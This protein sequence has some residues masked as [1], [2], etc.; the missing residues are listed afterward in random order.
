MGRAKK[1]FKKVGDFVTN[2]FVVTQRGNDYD[3]SIDGKNLFKNKLF[4]EGG[5]DTLKAFGARNELYGGSGDDFLRA[6]GVS[7]KMRGEAG[8]DEIVGLGLHN[9]M[10]GGTGNDTLRGAG[11]YNDMRGDEGNDELIGIGAYNA[12]NGGADDDVVVG[13]GAYNDMKGGAGADRL[14][15]I[16]AINRM[17]GGSGNDVV[18]AAGAVNHIHGGAGNDL[19]T[20]IGGANIIYGDDGDDIIVAGGLSNTVYGGAGDDI[21]VSVGGVNGMDGGEGND[22]MVAAGLLAT[23]QDGGAGDDV[24]IA[25]STAANVQH[26]GAG[27]DKMVALSQGGNYQ[28][29][30]SGNDILVGIGAGN[31][32]FG[33]DGDD[34]MVGLGNLNEQR[35]GSGNDIMVGIGK[36]N[37]Q[38]GDDGNDILVGLGVLGNI[39]HGGAG[40]D[41]LFSLGQANLQKGQAGDDIM[42]ALGRVNVQIGGAGDDIAFALGQASLQ[43]GE[44]GDD[45]L[46][47]AGQANIQHGGA[48]DDIML[49]IGKGN[50]QMGSGGSDIVIGLGKGNVQF[51]GDVLDVVPEGAGGDEPDAAPEGSDGDALDAVPDELGLDSQN[52]D[53]FARHT[54]AGQEGTDTNILVAAGKGN[55]Q[56]GDAGRDIA[57]TLGEANLQLLGKGD[58]VGVALGKKAS[59]QFG[60]AGKDVLVNMQFAK[61]GGVYQS[62]GGDSDTMITFFGGANKSPLG[63]QM[64]DSGDDVM[65]MISQDF[66]KELFDKKK[67]SGSDSKATGQG[68]GVT[69]QSGGSGD[70]TFIDLATGTTLRSGGA[71]NDTFFSLGKGGIAFGGD[72]NDLMIGGFKQSSFYA[73]G[74]GDDVMLDMNSF[75]GIMLTKHLV[76]PALEMV[77]KMVDKVVAN[78]L[79]EIQFVIDGIDGVFTGIGDFLAAIELHFP[80]IALPDIPF[81][82]NFD[83][84]LDKFAK[85]LDALNLDIPLDEVVA[86]L[87]AK[88]SE[89]LTNAVDLL[90]TDI[91]NQVLGAVAETVNGLVGQVT[92]AAMDLAKV[93]EL[94]F[95]GVIGT[96]LDGVELVVDGVEGTIRGIED[97]AEYLANGIDGALEDILDALTISLPDLSLDLG[98]EFDF[99]PDFNFLDHIGDFAGAILDTIKNFDFSAGLDFVA[100][101]TEA[102]G[103][104]IKSIADAASLDGIRE[105]LEALGDGI[106]D[107]VDG[108]AAFFEDMPDFGAILDAIGGAIPDLGDVPDVIGKFMPEGLEDLGTKLL[109]LY[110]LSG[111][112][113]LLGGDGDDTFGISGKDTKAFGGAGDD[114]YLVSLNKIDVAFIS[115]GKLDGDLMDAISAAGDAITAVDGGDAGL[116]SEAGGADTLEL[117]ALLGVAPSEVSITRVPDDIPL[118]GGSLIVTYVTAARAAANA[119]AIYNMKDLFSFDEGVTSFEDKAR[120]VAAKLT[121]TAKGIADNMKTVFLTNMENEDKRIETLRLVSLD[122]E[123][124]EIDLAGA[125]EA[126]VFSTLPTEANSSD[127]A[128]FVT[129]NN[130]AAE[131]RLALEE[132][133]EEGTETIRDGVKDLFNDIKDAGQD[134]LD[135]GSAL[136]TVEVEEAPD[137]ETYKEEFDENAT[138]KDFLTDEEMA[139]KDERGDKN[140]G[141]Y[142]EEAGVDLP[143]PPQALTMIVNELNVYS[144]E[145][146]QTLA[147]TD[148][149]FLVLWAADETSGPHKIHAQRVDASGQKIGAETLLATDAVSVHQWE[150][151]ALADNEFVLRA[152]NYK[153][154]EHR[155]RALS[156]G[157]IVKLADPA[158]GT[159]FKYYLKTITLT[160]GNEVRID[161]IRYQ[162]HEAKAAVSMYDPDG[163]HTLVNGHF[164][165]SDYMRQ[166]DLVALADGGFVVVFQHTKNDRDLF[167]RIYNEDG[168]ARTGYLNPALNAAAHSED[169]E[170]QLAALADGSFLLAYFKD[171]GDDEIHVIRLDATGEKIGEDLVISGSYAHPSIAAQADGT[172]AITYVSNGQVFTAFKAYGLDLEGTAAADLIEGG[173]GDD[174]IEAGLGDDAIFGDEGDDILHGE[175]GDDFIE[176]G[177]G[178]DRLDGGAGRDVL[179][180]GAGDDVLTG[181]SGA[182]TFVFSIAGTGIFGTDTITDFAPGED[183]LDLL[184]LAGIDSFDDLIFSQDGADTVISTQGGTI[185]LEDTLVEDITEDDVAHRGN[186]VGEYGTIQVNEEVQ[187]ISTLQHYENPVVVA[188][189]KSLNEIDIVEARVSNVSSNG[190]DIQLQETEDLDGTHAIETVQFMVVEAGR[191]ELSNGAVIEAGTVSTN[192][193]FQSTR[194]AMPEE[195]T[196]EGELS[197]AD[198]RV[199]A[200]VNSRNGPEFATARVDDVSETGFKISMAEREADRSGHLSETIGF[201]AFQDGD[202]GAFETGL[203]NL[204]DVRQSVPETLDFAQITEINGID[205]AILR[206][207][208]ETGEVFVQEDLSYD[209]ETEH[210]QDEVS[211]LIFEQD[212]GLLLV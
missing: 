128:A 158:D 72:G 134:L 59:V 184:G 139:A 62:G 126:G 39:Q 74:A 88:L 78:I 86:E 18:V 67:S 97:I 209:A 101:V 1:F 176:G 194:R 117:R 132:K 17:D 34:V 24:M 103:Q 145:V 185:R 16:G 108:I 160:N 198:T 205:P 196:F 52:K 11:A 124:T 147:M 107:G 171:H 146:T 127:L 190:F 23:T 66:Y 96:L 35:G 163:N 203:L 95:D 36:G 192:A 114:T 49:A 211:F 148:G 87:H 79:T 165:A 151:M 80:G 129:Q 164:A 172:V 69:F 55:L 51:G 98:F 9:D 48:D 70:D 33:E 136:E 175:D 166:G 188:F 156:D 182:D 91:V 21:M 99:L 174:S 64:G 12:M 4:G 144:L 7:N 40:N 73:G 75:V 46:V 8:N 204:T 94:A 167:V 90:D 5:D 2:Q 83:L 65:A 138:E 173:K 31:F 22:I 143:P 89:I 106:A 14:I 57:L 118:F 81:S 177:A 42:V 155:F 161:N 179:I 29:G 56:F 20:S 159:F 130:S 141:N 162:A 68:G 206:Q 131:F 170:P 58:D 119:L 92:T 60:E 61:N 45:I 186:T 157:G 104:V 122:G 191:H 195:V 193:V 135:S 111:G 25:V 152:D 197:G 3:N 187:S 210:V 13:I 30:G 178:A 180:G 43:I 121:G 120:A 202:F 71:G 50:L 93:A 102:L 183:M 208:L 76:R 207:D 37:D 28:H 19:I 15:G 116:I 140:T 133:I 150:A 53:D 105:L 199:F 6:I 137:H 41:I 82:F 32:Q 113:R 153:D 77:D 26:G 149:S 85:L 169:S 110:E 63:V 181:G 47:A 125:V 168:S 200:T 84:G 154:G 27:N 123:T 201:V 38:F 100:H 189:V 109:T 112:D 10:S 44:D 142:A 115:E 212:E 54:G